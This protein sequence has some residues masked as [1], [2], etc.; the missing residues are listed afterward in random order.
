M[1]HLSSQSEPEIEEAKQSVPEERHAM[2]LGITEV[3]PQREREPDSEKASP[4]LCVEEAPEAKQES[5]PAPA[6]SKEAHATARKPAQSISDSA[7]LRDSHRSK[8]E[9]NAP[10]PSTRDSAILF[11]AIHCAP[12]SAPVPVS[13][14]Q[15]IQHSRGAPRFRQASRSQSKWLQSSRPLPA[16]F[17]APSQV[18]SNCVCHCDNR[19]VR[20]ASQPAT[21]QQVIAPRLRYHPRKPPDSRFCLGMQ[22][23]T[24][25]DCIHAPPLHVV[26]SLRTGDSPFFQWGGDLGPRPVLQYFAY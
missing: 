16:P 9:H 23:E 8:P 18:N 3:A 10:M 22:I 5:P 2:C 4:P 24:H 25:R 26:H 11:G 13:V 20:V 6:P 17:R 21:S 15:R 12:R 7:S 14:R 19:P 1:R